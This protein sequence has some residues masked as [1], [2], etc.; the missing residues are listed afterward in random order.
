MRCLRFLTL[1]CCIAGAARAQS[2]SE[3]FTTLA[4]WT[5][6]AKAGGI[7]IDPLGNVYLP[8]AADNEVLK[9][10][11]SGSVS[12]FVSGLHGPSAV[13]FDSQ[14]NLYIA[15]GAGGDVLKVSTAGTVSTF[16]SSSSLVA[17]SN[18][19]GAAPFTSLSGIAV[20]GSG[21][22]YVASQHNSSVIK[23]TPAGACAQFA[24]APWSLNA[25]FQTTNGVNAAQEYQDGAAAAALFNSPTG[26]AVDSQGN[27]YVAD[28]GNGAV[29]EISGGRVTTL[30]GGTSGAVIDGCDWL[31]LDLDG[32]IYITGQTVQELTTAGQVVDLASVDQNSWP[33]YVNGVGSAA[34]FDGPTGIAYRPGMAEP[35]NTSVPPYAGDPLLYIADDNSLRKGIATTYTNAQLAEPVIVSAAP[36]GTVNAGAAAPTLA[37]SAN[38]L[39]TYEWLLNGTPIPGATAATYT[40]GQVGS[41]AWS[42]SPVGVTSDGSDGPARQTGPASTGVVGSVDAGTYQVVVTDPYGN[43][44][45]LNM[46][47]LTVNENAWLLNLSGRAQVG[48]GQNALIAGFVT[49]GPGSKSV[50]VRGDGPALA[51]FGVS[52]TVTAPQ[53]QLFNGSTAVTGEISGWAA[54]LKPIF[55]ATGAFLFPNGS[56]DDATLQTVTP[57]AYTAIISSP[58]GSPG[59]GIAEVYDAD[60]ASNAANGTSFAGPPTNRLVNLSARANVGSGANVLIGGFVIA[61]TTAKTVLLRAPGPSLAYAPFSLSNAIAGTT[62]S[63]YDS[64]SQLIASTAGTLSPVTLGAS[65]LVTGANVQVGLEPSSYAVFQAAGA[66]SANW[67]ANEASVVATLPPGAYTIIV[68]GTDNATGVGMV[69]I[70]ELN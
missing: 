58:S 13:A 14:D 11:P 49:A 51:Q 6:S 31:A 16:A 24:G 2:Q 33:H 28:T 42:N 8:I 10:T 55:S 25:I 56:A 64:S 34:T 60:A 53:L 43:T 19:G 38:S 67:A 62:L 3:Y 63:L 15:E 65:A 17:A 41:Y 18:A 21:N 47:S 20:D 37:V 30:A 50:L 27:V 48:T 68:S 61:G 7:A 57:G 12:T 39:Y 46:G 1:I 5:G 36:G 66:Y 59:I 4:T 45:T 26:L 40:P 52:G 69:E 23:I 29:R 32:N 9:V 54:S 70:Y 22:V 44:Q 35:A